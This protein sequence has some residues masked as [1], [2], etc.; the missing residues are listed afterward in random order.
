MVYINKKGKIDIDCRKLISSFCALV[1][2][3]FF[4]SELN[5]SLINSL[6]PPFPS[7]NVPLLVSLTKR[8]FLITNWSFLKAYKDVKSMGGDSQRE[9]VRLSELVPFNRKFYCTTKHFSNSRG[10]FLMAHLGYL[11]G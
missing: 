3:L 10:I 4:L 6:G 2:H 1:I 5:F 7:E 11:N 9:S 8:T